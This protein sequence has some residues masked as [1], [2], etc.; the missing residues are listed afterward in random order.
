MSN[1][2][3]HDAKTAKSGIGGGGWNDRRRL[4]QYGVNHP[5][6]SIDSPPAG[7]E[8]TN[9]ASL[10]QFGWQS[11]TTDNWRFLV[12]R[13]PSGQFYDPGTTLVCRIC[14]ELLPKIHVSRMA[15][16]G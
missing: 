12:V 6:P 7:V 9:S 2:E 10:Q 1:K 16:R 4:C 5:E 11:H 15:Q 3:Q 14:F 8:V 13:W